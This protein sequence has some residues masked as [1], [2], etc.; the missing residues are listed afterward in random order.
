M[1][2]NADHPEA[3]LDALLQCVVC[4]ELI[5]WRR[6]ARKLVIVFTDQLFHVAGDGLVRD[7]NVY[8]NTNDVL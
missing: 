7:D 4:T 5:G 1:V 3:M 2:T 6:E 8:K